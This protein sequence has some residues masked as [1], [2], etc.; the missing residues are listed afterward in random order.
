MGDGT[1]LR[2]VPLQGRTVADDAY[3]DQRAAAARAAADGLTAVALAKVVGAGYD[4]TDVGVVVEFAA[5]HVP[6]PLIGMAG[7]TRLDEL[8]GSALILIA[9]LALRAAAAEAAAA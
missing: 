2:R 8:V 1:Q 4:P 9:E 3:N 5:T 6:D 7:S